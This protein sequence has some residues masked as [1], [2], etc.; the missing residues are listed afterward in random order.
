MVWSRFGDGGPNPPHAE[1]TPYAAFTR[2]NGVGAF[3]PFRRVSPWGTPYGRPEHPA[4]V[5]QW[6]T[7]VRVPMPSTVVIN[8]RAEACS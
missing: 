8:T 3:R 2:L 5:S 6:M 4:Q 1:L 7:S